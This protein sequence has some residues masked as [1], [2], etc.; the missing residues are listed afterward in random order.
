MV[1]YQTKLLKY[2]FFFTFENSN[3]KILFEINGFVS[4]F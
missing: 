2:S 1:Q 4:Y 3:L